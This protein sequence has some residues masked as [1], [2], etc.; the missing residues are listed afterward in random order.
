MIDRIV[1]QSPDKRECHI[2]SDSLIAIAL[3][4]GRNMSIELNYYTNKLL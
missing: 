2:A 4:G 3:I 1:F